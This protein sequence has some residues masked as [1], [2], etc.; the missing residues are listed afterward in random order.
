VID[1]RTIEVPRVFRLIQEWGRIPDEEMWRVFNMG[2]G[3]LAIVADGEVAVGLLRSRDVDAWICGQVQRTP[4]VH[5]L[6][7]E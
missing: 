5:L 3:M 1:T 7:G 4:G 2:A 6:G